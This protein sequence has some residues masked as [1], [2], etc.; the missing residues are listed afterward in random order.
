LRF[1]VTADWSVEKMFFASAASAIRSV[2][3]LR[4][5]RVP[6][7]GFVN[8]PFTVLASLASGI[9][10]AVS[11]TSRRYSSRLSN[12]VV[13]PSVASSRAAISS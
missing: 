12:R 11:L 4:S 7:A 3:P 5:S 13:K 2:K 6:A 9:C 8:P 10:F 1:T